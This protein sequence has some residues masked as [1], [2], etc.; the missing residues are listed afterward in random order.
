MPKRL[1][2]RAAVITGAGR[3]IGRA[4]AVCLA[5]EGA[6]VVVNDY[7]VT[8]GGADPSGG[9]ADDV[10]AEIRAKGGTAVANYGDVS[11]YESAG[12]IID[13]CVQAFGKIDILGNVAGIARRAATWE[14]SEED[15]WAV[16][17]V[18]MYGSFNC[19]RHAA[20]HM[21]KQRYGRIVTMSSRGGL[22]GNFGHPSY[23]AGKG[24]MF[25]LMNCLSRELGPYGITCNTM[26]PGLT[27][28][29]QSAKRAAQRAEAFTTM[30][31]EMKRRF[32]LGVLQPEDVAPVFAYLCSEDAGYINGQLVIAYGPV[33][34]LFGPLTITR[35]IQKEGHWTLDDLCQ[36]AP[37][38]LGE[39]LVNPSPR[40]MSLEGALMPGQKVSA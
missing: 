19:S 1:K 18:H 12:K 34:S 5:A 6:L 40:G 20:P 23:G 36:T 35:T 15:F 29:R 33:V 17:K 38:T 22:L 21:M 30:A 10:V 8:I 28:T 2:G 16:V 4:I 7:G 27:E 24:G 11:N 14:V 31:P 32:A 3:G 39:N 25:G 13:T 37:G 9:P 26:V